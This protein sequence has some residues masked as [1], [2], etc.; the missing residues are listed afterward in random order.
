MLD[1]ELRYYLSSESIIRHPFMRILI[2]LIG[3]QLTSSCLFAQKAL[4]GLWTGTLSNDSTTI[5]NDQ[6][7]EIALTQY[8]DKVYGYTRN[9]FIVND[10]LYYIV[11]RVKGKVEGNIC[12]VKDDEI[13]SYN[14]RGR[15][16]KGVKVSYTFRMNEADSSWQLDGDWKTNRTKRF[17]SIS[18]KAELKEEKNL[19]NSKLFPHL[20][21]LKQGKDM[22]FYAKAKAPAPAPTPVLKATTA[23]TKQ[24]EPKEKASANKSDEV[25]NR[26]KTER[27]RKNEKSEQPNV[28][29]P[30]A[31]KE[32]PAPTKEKPV[33]SKKAVVEKK[34]EANIVNNNLPPQTSPPVVKSTTERINER[35]SAAPQMVEFSSDSL[36][37]ALYD[38]GEVDGDTVSVLLNGEVLLEKQGL[39]ASAVR[40]NILIP[41]GQNELTLVL[42]AE[43][44][45]AYPP[46]TGLLVIRDGDKQYQLRF[47]A[48]LKQNAT[49]IL[50]RKP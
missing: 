37:L 9:S 12:E 26:N 15:I 24:A 28:N 17:Y 5:R 49:I 8:R 4:T 3:L 33:A 31:R 46:N 30:I 19:D 25:N 34:E 1:R 38:N 39:K 48:D 2:L 29:P 13:L 27:T 35:V 44:L 40:K 36:V 6:S 18:G 42:F 47:S 7:F 32:E 22:E 43:N 41:S 11:K 21:E 23:N 50:R 10:T 20:E 16:D 14:F 45:G